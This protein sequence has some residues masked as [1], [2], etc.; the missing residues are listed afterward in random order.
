MS[1]LY[2]NIYGN[3]VSEYPH[4]FK[5]QVEVEEIITGS[6]IALHY[7]CIIICNRVLTLRIPECEG[8]EL[9]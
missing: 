9:L 3:R 6:A 7:Y 1:N 4:M 8:A 2:L 5:A